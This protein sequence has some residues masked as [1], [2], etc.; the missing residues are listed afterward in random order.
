MIKKYLN[1]V[2]IEGLSGMALG[3]FATLIM[4]TILCQIGDLLGPGFFGGKPSHYLILIGSVAKTITGAGIGVGVASKYQESPLVSV[5]A[6][7]AGMIGAFPNVNTSM[8]FVIGKPGEPLGA[9]VAA[10]V[11]IELGHIISGKTQLDIILTPFVGIMSGG[12]AGIWVGKPIARFMLWVGEL[13]NVNV[14]KQPIVGGLIVAVIMGMVLTLPI[15]SA[16]IGI[17]LGLSGLAAGAATIGCCC[18]MVGFAV[19]SFREN[20][21]GGLISQGVGTS[22]LQITNILRHPFIWIPPIVSSAILGPVGAA[23][24]KMKSNSTGSGMGTSGLVGPIMSY[25]TMT[26]SMS[27]TMALVEVVVMEFVLPAIITLIIAEGMR[28]I[29]LIHDGDMKLE[30]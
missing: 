17:S 22:M 27:N 10:Y 11:A 8:A 25:Q 3:L 9:F 5:S 13:V 26:K 7:V 20:K 1:R 14:D 16:A 12:L 24:L 15:S 18:Q 4:G 28:K 2:F 23:V 30:A 6:A 19:A 21:V 29:K